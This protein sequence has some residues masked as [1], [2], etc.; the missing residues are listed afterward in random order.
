MQSRKSITDRLTTKTTSFMN[1]LMELSHGRNLQSKEHF[2]AFSK[3]R[4][5]SLESQRVACHRVDREGGSHAKSD[6]V[7]DKISMHC[8]RTGQIS[9]RKPDTAKTSL[10]G[11]NCVG[12]PERSQNAAA[13]RWQD[14]GV[15]RRITFTGHIDEPI[16]DEE[17]A[18]FYDDVTEKL[19]PGHLIREAHQEEFEFLNTFLVY[20]K[21]PEANAKGKERVSV[22]WCDVSKGCGSSNMAVRSRLVGREYRWEEPLMQS[23]FAATLPLQSLRYVLHWVHTCRRQ[24]GRKLDKKLL[25]LDGSRAHIHQ[26]A[27]R[28]LY[29]TLPEEDETLGM[30]GQLLRTLHGPRD[31]AHERD[32]FANTKI[33]EVGYQV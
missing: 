4:R 12:N 2:F 8:R 17:L 11:R 25:V 30:V 21:V 20:R 23:T 33:P 19:L 14:G 32:D 10:S 29:I 7:A 31:A 5:C 15:F 24:H 1:I 26:P 18:K 9:S 6:W 28:E 13:R 22:R 27:V 3:E 16:E